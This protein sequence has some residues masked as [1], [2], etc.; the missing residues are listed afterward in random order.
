MAYR[1]SS[2]D[3]IQI[4]AVPLETE[5]L[6][7]GVL[8]QG[9]MYLFYAADDHKLKSLLEIET[10]SGFYECLGRRAHNRIRLGEFSNYDTSGKVYGTQ[11]MFVVR[12]I[13]DAETE[14]E[15]PYPSDNQSGRI[16]KMSNPS[17]VL[18]EFLISYKVIDHLDLTDRGCHSG[19][20]VG[21][22]C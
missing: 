12:A 22:C 2:H 3:G 15:A 21:D 19:G 11:Y 7:P 5:S 4:G 16:Y 20:G 8:R 18:P 6:E 1:W 9:E 10:E 17:Q 13:I 14:V